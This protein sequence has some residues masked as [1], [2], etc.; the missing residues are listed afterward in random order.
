M[1]NTMKLFLISFFFFFTFFVYG[2]T[3]EPIDGETEP[4]E[5]I[6]TEDA[7]LAEVEQ[8]HNE[9]GADET[10][11]PEK[12]MLSK[13]EIEEMVK[14]LVEEEIAKIEKSSTDQKKEKEGKDKPD[15]E[16][17][18][19]SD[20]LLAPNF[21]HNSLTFVMGDDNLR[22]NSL[23]SPKFDI[24]SR[25]EY[26]DW[27][28]RVYGYSNRSRANTKLSLF[29]EEK[30]LIKN[31][32]ARIGISIGI[33]NS[34]D[35]QSGRVNTTVREEKSFIELDYRH[36][37]HNRF[38]LTLY[39]YNADNIAVGYFRGLRWGESKVWPQHTSGYPAPGFQLLYGY[40]D[41]SF[42]FGFKARPQEISDKLG[43]E[44]VPKET[45]YGFFG[46]T[47]YFNRELG[48]KSHLQ[49]AVINKGNNPTINDAILA[50]KDDDSIISY[51]LDLFGEYFN[52]SEFGDPLNINTYRDGVWLEP[53]YSTTL[54]MRVRAEYMFQNQR[55]GNA[56][57]LG[58]INVTSPQP[59]TENFMGH[60]VVSELSLRFKKLR[61]SF[62]YS[63]R[64]LPFMVFDAP[65]VEPYQTISSLA[66]Q[67]P[68]HLFHVWADYNIQNFWF[69]VF[70]GFKIPATYTVY[71]ANGQKTVTVI[72][73]RIVSNQVTNAFSQSREVLP[74]GEDAVN[75]LF[76]KLTA[77]YKF[78]RSVSAIL[79]YSFTQDH[80]RARYVEKTNSSG[81]GTGEFVY[82]WDDI[83][84]KDIHG[85]MFLV[86]GRF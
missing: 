26:E 68:E 62:L 23:Y 54:A 75:M 4:V 49:G 13:E 44:L 2:Q 22:D 57:Y 32:S 14:K 80:N 50:H 6:V 36:P 37:S 79:E 12:R 17:V 81:K 33:Q 83:K 42:Y 67:S 61:A 86:E 35:T 29:H 76:L 21:S 20:G 84:V 82:D 85:L 78:S 38:K 53:D 56:D 69:G 3:G 63:F 71:D 30:G 8:V 70:Y 51:S 60:G 52:G 72:K 39:P 43:T 59:I 19:E 11:Q 10:V 34:W 27:S 77:K 28:E 7:A 1:E 65:G 73:E 74:P 24:G 58:E 9:A 55:L 31:L 18:Q 15:S 41:I 47:S 46:G 25:T 48:L 40:R 64:T 45:V 16:K 5:E 66:E